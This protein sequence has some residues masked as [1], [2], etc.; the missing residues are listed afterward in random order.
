[1][2][3][4]E[5]FWQHERIALQFS[6]GRDSLATLLLLREFWPQ[7]TV[8]WLSTG[9]NFPEMLELVDRVEGMVPR[10]VKVQSDSAL[11]RARYGWPVDLLPVRNTSRGRAFEGEALKL[12]SR[13]TC[14]ERSIMLPMHE[15]MVAD[16]I[17]LI[18]RGQRNTDL[19]KGP[20]QSGMVVG[21]VQ[22][23]YPIE[24]WD[25]HEVNC[26]IEDSGWQVPRFYELMSAT[27]D[28]MGCTAYLHEGKG[29]YLY[30]YHPEEYRVFIKRLE[31]IRAET[32]KA[33]A[34]LLKEL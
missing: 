9:D 14:C 20:L 31:A 1:M 25:D 5:Y 19:L 11:V 3:L 18:I 6:G 7:L 4:R 10:F 26:F 24:T 28:C 13:Y 21:G 29:A 30:K 27:P 15:R 33:L 22:F 12:Q 16:D 23:L 34:P 8:Y 32:D 2:S 17:T